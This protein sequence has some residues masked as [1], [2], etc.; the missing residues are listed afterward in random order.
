[1]EIMANNFK[2]KP[3]EIKYWIKEVKSCVDRQKRDLELRNNYPFLIN[4]YEGRQTADG[5]VRKTTNAEKMGILN[6]YFPNVNTLIADVWYTFPEIIVE[7][8][9]DKVTLNG[10]EVCSLAFLA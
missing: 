5:A 4:Y 7:A 10:V 3:D 8:T 2:L 1:M 6:D 9:K